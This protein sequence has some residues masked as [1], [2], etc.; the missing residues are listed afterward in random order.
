MSKIDIALPEN[1][2]LDSKNSEFWYRNIRNILQPR[3][4]M[5]FIESYY[6]IECKDKS[7]LTN[8]KLEKA[9]KEQVLTDYLR[10]KRKKKQ[11]PEIMN[12]DYIGKSESQTVI[13]K[14]YI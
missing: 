8:D 11:K 10:G 3:G 4:L 14:Y 6:L 5:K 7:T 2:H 1:D 13:K 12:I 9:T